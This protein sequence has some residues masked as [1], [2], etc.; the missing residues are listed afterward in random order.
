M[1]ILLFMLANLLR[2]ET[3]SHR[4][5]KTCGILLEL[6]NQSVKPQ[7]ILF[8]GSKLRLTKACEILVPILMSIGM[9]I[10]V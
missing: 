1:V 2:S 3:A 6:I 10:L 5:H 7:H 9:P 4:I 8:D